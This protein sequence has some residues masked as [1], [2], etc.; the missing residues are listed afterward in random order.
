[1]QSQVECILNCFLLLFINCEENNPS[2]QY[3]MAI[4]ILDIANNMFVITEI[5]LRNKVNAMLYL[6]KTG[7]GPHS[8]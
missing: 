1:M 8:S 2:A 3:A 7:N 6:V 4:N 5:T